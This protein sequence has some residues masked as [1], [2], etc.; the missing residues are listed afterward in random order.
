MSR[1]TL[2]HSIRHK[3]VARYPLAE[4]DGGSSTRS[5]E[6]ALL[7]A[8]SDAAWL[9]DSDGR[10]LVANTSFA[11]LLGRSRDDIIGSSDEALQLPEAAA[12]RQRDEQVMATGSAVVAEDCLTGPDGTQRWFETIVS[13]VRDEDGALIGT[14]GIARDITARKLAGATTDATARRL[15]AIFDESPLGIGLSDANGFVVESNTA[16]QR[17]VGYSAEELRHR[18]FS[19]LSSPAD[20]SENVA[21]FHDL[22]TGRTSSY[23]VEKTYRHRS[24]QQVFVRVTSAAVRD[25]RD[26][27]LYSV[28]MVEDVTKMRLA[29]ALLRDRQEVFQALTEQ[30][31]EMNAIIDTNGNVC[32]ASPSIERVLGFSP[33]DLVGKSPLAFVHQD[34]ALALRELFEAV[35]ADPKRCAT[36]LIRFQHA[37]GGYRTIEGSL[38][39]LLEHRAV[40]GIVISARDV[41][42][43]VRAAE[44]IRFQADLLDAVEQAVIAIDEA[45]CVTAWNKHAELLYGWTR[46]DALGRPIDS[47]IH[48]ELPEG[49]IPSSAIPRGEAGTRERLIRRR[50]GTTFVV[51]VTPSPIYGRDG[52]RRGHVGVSGDVTTRRSLEEQIR[53]AQK[54]ET[55][56]RLAGGIAHDFNNLLTV[57]IAHAEFLLRGGP[58]AP[59]WRDDIGKITEAAMRAATLTRQLLAFGRKQVL[60][61]RTLALNE[62][63]ERIGSVLDASIGEEIRLS[64]SLAPDLPPIFA[65]PGQLEQVIMNLAANAC[66]AMPDGGLL[67]LT[68]HVASPATDATLRTT[69]EYPIAEYVALSITDTG[70]GMDPATAAQMFE[71]FY[72]T[73]G[74]ARGT[75]LGLST[76][77]GIIK[78]SGGSI[79]VDTGVGEG[80]TVTI[81]LPIAHTDTAPIIPI[82]ICDVDAPANAEVILVVEDDS[83]VRRL[84]SRLLTQAGYDVVGAATAEAAILYLANATSPI[85]LVL[86]DVV[87]PG[88]SGHGLGEEVR[89]RQPHTAV[90]YMS[91]CT[92]D[93]V[94]QRGLLPPGTAF[95]PKP[96]TTQELLDAIRDRLAGVT[97]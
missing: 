97:R 26:R 34:D 38:T 24:G 14:S 43:R 28:G 60:L 15:R 50:D 65:D 23:T 82:R 10:Y 66:D 35:A 19:E 27:L 77:Y 72:T 40:R 64:L 42:E 73:K 16:Y 41:T 75:G 36:S 70:T 29:E 5:A 33:E 9:K 71:P 59:E 32:Y 13:P 2:D 44:D 39:N 52:V 78:Q 94:S 46:A 91:G 86:T 84:T 6:L 45:D 4:T 83:A 92:D 49:N 31:S 54:M 56:G 93:E 90:M 88:M 48:A 76:V 55:V 25:D 95:L 53:Q 63:I 37:G 58:D 85:S 69:T 12:A 57:V 81:Y 74:S 20:A 7:N 61:P 47:L 79:A 30:T 51:A 17:M 21:L 3:D 67:T 87:M 68:T 89:R 8:I 80:T 22:V 11:S 18:R 1:P 62:V 96:F